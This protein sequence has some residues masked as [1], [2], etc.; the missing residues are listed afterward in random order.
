MEFLFEEQIESALSDLINESKDKL[1]IVSPYIK[2]NERIKDKLKSKF[3]K[4]NCQITILFGKSDKSQG[5][6]FDTLNIDSFN[7]LKSL[8]NVEI[9]YNQRMHA[10]FYANDFEYILT[11]MNLYDYSIHNNFEIG[12]RQDY[13]Q[14]KAEGFS[15]KLGSYMDKIRFKLADKISGDEDF[16]EEILIAIQRIESFIG[17]SD[18][19]YKAEH[20]DHKNEN[21][22]FNQVLTDKLTIQTK[23][24]KEKKP[25]QNEADFLGSSS[26]IIYRSGTQLSKELN[27]NKKDFDLLMMKQGY[28]DEKKQITKLGD[29][30]GLKLTTHNERTFVQFPRELALLVCENSSKPIGY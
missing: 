24:Q 17:T 1:I 7:F 14:E 23:Q 25:M 28:L 20:S 6:Y 12:F 26:K 4:N 27:L 5:D 21:G 9:Y 29:M 10:K 19:L 22:C 2:F 18:L 30:V 11:S 13:N 16:N 15:E 8:P 3:T